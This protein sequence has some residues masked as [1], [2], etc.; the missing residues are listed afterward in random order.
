MTVGVCIWQ[1]QIIAASL[2]ARF[3]HDKSVGNGDSVSVISPK[4]LLSN[5]KHQER[6]GIL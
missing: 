3:E 6:I 2:I 1:T 5:V 4:F